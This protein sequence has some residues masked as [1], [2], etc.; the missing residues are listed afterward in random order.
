MFPQPGGKR[1][2]PFIPPQI[3]PCF[4]VHDLPGSFELRTRGSILANLEIP[5]AT[6]YPDLMQKIRLVQECMGEWQCY[7][8]LPGLLE[9]IGGIRDP[10][11][12]VDSIYIGGSPIGIG[13]AEGGAVMGV[14]L[15]ILHLRI[16]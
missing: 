7:T 2:F 10:V 13:G 16:W 3:V 12:G 9:E 4:I 1:F 5:F 6:L 15:N 14:T 8:H 11:T